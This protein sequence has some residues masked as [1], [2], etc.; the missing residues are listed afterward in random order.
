MNLIE[1]SQYHFGMFWT[2]SV[3]LKGVPADD[4]FCNPEKIRMSFLE[5]WVN[6]FLQ[7]FRD[8][9]LSF[10]LVITFMVIIEF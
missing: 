10:I 5:A 3:K 8:N 9:F 1:K 7:I 6:F 2:I 4:V